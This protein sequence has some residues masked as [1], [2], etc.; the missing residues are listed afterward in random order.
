MQSYVEDWAASQGLEV[1]SW[2][3]SGDFGDAYETTCGR[4]IKITSD[5]KEFMAAFSIQCVKSNY[6]VDIHKAEL[7]DEDQLL[8]L[9]EKLDTNGIEDVF[10]DAMSLIDEYS[11]GEW[12]YF[13]KDE[14]PEDLITSEKSINLIDDICSSIMDLRQKGID[15]PDIHERNIG[16]KNGRYV[17]FDFQMTENRSYDD[18]KTYILGEQSKKNTPGRIS[19]PSAY[20]SM[21]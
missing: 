3:G 2:L 14:L 11:F 7:T 21:Q 13:D 5:I 20:L 16:M 19:Q 9:M 17:L 10:N 12:E 18:F 6:L 8:I 15:I 1:E 4:V